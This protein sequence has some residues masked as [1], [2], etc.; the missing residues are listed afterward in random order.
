MMSNYSQ[1]TSKWQKEKGS[2]IE[3]REQINQ[4]E[5]QNSQDVSVCLEDGQHYDKH[6]CRS[7]AGDGGN[8]LLSSACKI[9]DYSLCRTNFSHFCGNLDDEYMNQR[10]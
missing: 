9:Q 2:I 10:I 1:V 3:D 4:P 8:E 5:F 7:E 6:I